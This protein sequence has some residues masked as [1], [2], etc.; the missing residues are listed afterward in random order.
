MEAVAKRAAG[1][2]E[3]E[4]ILG[5]VEPPKPLEWVPLVA[6]LGVE[7]KRVR[8]RSGEE[9]VYTGYRVRIPKE[10][11]ERLGLRGEAT[12]LLQAARPRW[13]HLLDYREEPLRSRF[14]AIKKPWVKAEICMLGHAPEELCKE[15]RTVTVIASE[16][17]LRRLGLEPGKPV[18]LRE[19]LERARSVEG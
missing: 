16:E 10:V 3:L 19:L 7:R 6:A 9:R 4:E 13:Y 12:I 17:E 14:K 1:E 8:L 18:T 2:S 15:Y 11:V 5:P